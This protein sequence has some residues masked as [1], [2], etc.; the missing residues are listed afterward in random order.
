[1]RIFYVMLLYVLILLVSTFAS[2]SRIEAMGKSEDFF[3]DDMSIFTNPA[4]MVLYKTYVIGELGTILYDAEEEN[5][6]LQ[7]TKT[8]DDSG[9][10]ISVDTTKG[11]DYDSDP[12]SVSSDENNRFMAGHDPYDPWFGGIYSYTLLVG[13]GAADQDESQLKRKSLGISVGAAF[14]RTDITKQ[15]LSSYINEYNS[16]SNNND[17]TNV[18]QPINEFDIMLAFKTKSQL[19]IGFGVYRTGYKDE[20]KNKDGK[21]NLRKS[22]LTGIKLGINKA[23]TSNSFLDTYVALNL[24]NYDKTLEMSKY[25]FN[26]I[27]ELGVDFRFR[28]FAQTKKAIQIIPLLKLN[29]LSLQA[30]ENFDGTDLMQYDNSEIGGGLGLGLNHKREGFEF[31]FG[32]TG[33]ALLTTDQDIQKTNDDYTTMEKG[34][35]VY[36]QINFGIEKQ[37]QNK[38]KWLALRAGC[39]KTLGIL[40]KLDS[41]A[42]GDLTLTT[43]SSFQNT[44]ADGTLD[45]LIGLGASINIQDHLK[46]DLTLAEDLPY[47]F[48]SIFSGLK[49]N[50]SSR[51]SVS[52]QF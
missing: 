23:F 51:V 20:V 41:Y 43:N 11:G 13:G 21:T 3:I 48:G 44:E 26:T 18:S 1:M 38:F 35:I 24:Y 17:T 33:N 30:L 25:N 15:K 14:N 39:K 50:V 47:T 37:L 4:N 31:N 6:V 22:D 40:N 8:V 19:G 9:N 45:D 42:D 2:N 36:A 49:G 34:T 46:L 29:I 27:S 16:L 10:V 12:G 28:F 7:V 52:Y 5:S 32:V